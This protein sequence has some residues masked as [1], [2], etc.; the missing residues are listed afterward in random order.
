M[1]HTITI[2]TFSAILLSPPLLNTPHV[3][4]KTKNCVFMSLGLGQLIN[5]NNQIKC[6][7]IGT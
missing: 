2:D 1:Y 7:L 5:P 3:D 4:S 6:L